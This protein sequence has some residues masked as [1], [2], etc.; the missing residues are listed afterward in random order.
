MDPIP[1]EPPEALRDTLRKGGVLFADLSDQDLAGILQLA[2]VVRYPAKQVVFLA[3]EE[4][5]DALL[6]V[7]EG[8]VK[9]S[10][11][12]AEGKE[13]ILC[14]L[15]PGE[16]FGEMS[17]LD[18][19]P[20]SATVTTM[21]ACRFLQIRRDDFLRFLEGH[22][23]VA[24]TLLATLSERLRATNDL[25][26]NLSFLNLSARL[27]RILL[28]LG[29]QYGKLGAGGIVI[30]LKL[31]QEELGNLA[32]V[33]RESVNRQLRLWVEAGVL[34]YDHGILVLKNSD[35]LFREALEATS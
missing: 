7:L 31:S 27:A 8:R 9:V 23:K 19:G 4:G 21:E 12:S 30:G 35:A 16:M 26:G 14:I 22:P 11:I 25:V 5:G 10:L 1:T 24:L 15:Q 32:G 13:A 17:L 33:S 18:G 20:R 6:V 3:G 29:Q 34:D 28:S 2:S